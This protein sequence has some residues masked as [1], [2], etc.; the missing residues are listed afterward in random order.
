VV[1]SAAATNA[2][3]A[4][5]AAEAAPA[6]PVRIRRGAMS[7]EIHGDVGQ[8]IEGGSHPGATFS[9]AMGKGKADAKK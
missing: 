2:S 8:R 6:K 3:Q 7:V 9:V 5:L 1:Y 4:L